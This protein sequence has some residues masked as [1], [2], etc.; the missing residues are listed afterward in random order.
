M[1][2]NNVICFYAYCDAHENE[3]MRVNDIRWER[4]QFNSLADKEYVFLSR[5]SCISQYG[6]MR[7]FYQGNSLEECKNAIE[8]A[9]RQVTELCKKQNSPFPE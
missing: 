5:F 1:L 8:S 7:L 3:E 4:S 6:E 9:L 2:S